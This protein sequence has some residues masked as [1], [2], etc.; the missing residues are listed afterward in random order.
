MTDMLWSPMTD[1]PWSPGTDMPWS[2]SE[3]SEGIHTDTN[4]QCRQCTAPLCCV[5][6]TAPNETNVYLRKYKSLS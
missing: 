3:A 4:T 5:V 1:M 6:Q 2:P